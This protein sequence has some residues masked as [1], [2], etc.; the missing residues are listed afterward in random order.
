MPPS[1]K[2]SKWFAPWVDAIAGYWQDKDL[3]KVIMLTH[4]LDR[5]LKALDSL[6]YSLSG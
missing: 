6:L 4:Q 3:K 2:L 5:S 1:C